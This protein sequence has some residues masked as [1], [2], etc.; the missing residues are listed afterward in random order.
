MLMGVAMVA[1]FVSAIPAWASGPAMA[2]FAGATVWFLLRGF[3][4]VPRTAALRLSATCLAMAYMLVPTAASAEVTHDMSHEHHEASIGAG[5]GTLDAMMTL[6]MI[7]VA[8]AAA[9][10]L[11]RPHRSR[12]D[13]LSCA[14]EVAMAV[15]M[16]LHVAV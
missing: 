10:A 1:M 7:V 8:I 5:I 6:A 4:D 16:G 12:L 15:S 14:C 11:A 9:V 2:G 3:R 13:R